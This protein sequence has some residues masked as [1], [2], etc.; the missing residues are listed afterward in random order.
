MLEVDVKQG[1]GHIRSNPQVTVTCKNKENYEGDDRRANLI[2]NPKNTAHIAAFVPQFREHE[3]RE[4]LYK[5]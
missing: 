4:Q 1:G 2:V 5:Q 3:I